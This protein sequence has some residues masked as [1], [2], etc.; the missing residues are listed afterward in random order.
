[1]AAPRED[2]PA[3]DR[4]FE[5]VFGDDEPGRLGTG[6]PSGTA[7][8]FLGTLGLLAV[9]VLWFPERLTTARFRALFGTAYLPGSS[10]PDRYGI[11]GEPV[12]EGCLGQLAHPFRFDPDA[13]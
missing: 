1:M 10:W 3:L 5:R 12:P 6:W 9:L 4:W 13:R 8:V 11:A 2:R 7:S